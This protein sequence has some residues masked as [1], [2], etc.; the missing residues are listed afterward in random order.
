ML[1]RKK[2]PKRKIYLKKKADTNKIKQDLT[3]LNINYFSKFQN[4]NNIDEKWNFFEKE[5][6]LIIDRNIPQKLT[7]TRLNLPW[8]TRVQRLLCRKKQRLFKKAKKS[9]LT[10]DWTT[11]KSFRKAVRKNLTEARN[12]Y[13]SNNLKTS[14]T[15]NPKKFWSFIKRL[16]SN[17]VGVSDLISDGKLHSNNKTKANILNNQFFSVFTLEDTS[18][19]P[20]TNPITSDKI[21]KLIISPDGVKKQL[22]NLDDNKASGPDQLPPWFLK[23]YADNLYEMLCDIFSTSV[24]LGSIP[25]RWKEANICSVFKKGNKNDP[26]NYRPISL[27]CVCCKILEHI[28]HSHVM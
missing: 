4:S 8:F 17:S 27:T 5:I 3:N 9:L 21:N 20:V 7:S 23:A 26:A 19:L 14:L 15:E 22:L 2:L 25:S 16:N 11:Y 28:I 18:S 10:Q 1:G 24:K 13:I 12:H 6:K